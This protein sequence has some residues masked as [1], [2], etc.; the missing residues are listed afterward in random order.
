MPYSPHFSISVKYK[1]LIMHL[2]GEESF[3]EKLCKGDVCLLHGVFMGER[4]SLRGSCLFLCIYTLLFCM[5]CKSKSSN[6]GEFKQSWKLHLFYSFEKYRSML[7][8]KGGKQAY[9]M[10]LSEKFKIYCF[11]VHQQMYFDTLTIV[12]V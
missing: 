11:S 1:T 3:N 4:V 2:R 9:T 8:K 5:S 6:L 10:P 12:Y 7:I